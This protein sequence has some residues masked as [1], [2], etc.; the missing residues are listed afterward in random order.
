MQL[1]TIKQND[2]IFIPLPKHIMA[3]V[4]SIVSNFDDIT[5]ELRILL[6]PKQENTI[7][8]QVQALSGSLKPYI[9][10]DDEVIEDDEKAFLQTILDDAHRVKTEFGVNN[11]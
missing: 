1:T 8:P 7:C 10:T 6:Y 2:G 11:D 9:G 5:H 4:D 3:N